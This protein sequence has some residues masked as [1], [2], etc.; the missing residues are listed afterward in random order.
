MTSTP[1][2][3]PDFESYYQNWHMSP[4]LESNGFIFLSG[5]TG[6]RTDGSLSVVPGEQIREAFQTLGKVSEHASAGYDS[7]VEMTSY[8]VGL[9]N[10]IMLFR[11][12]KDEFIVEP[13]PAWTAIEVAGFA[14]DGAI[15][16]LRMIAQRAT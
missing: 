2:I 15:V 3:P 8:H 10:H 4:G 9:H 13:Y 11:T 6:A 12:I 7:I 16:E 5:F 14:L 1:I